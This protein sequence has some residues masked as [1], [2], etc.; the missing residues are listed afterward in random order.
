M[1]NK[2]TFENTN[3]FNIVLIKPNNISHLEYNSPNYINQILNNDCYE[4]IPCNS[5]NFMEYLKTL[6]QENNKNSI[7]HNKDGLE[8]ISQV[9]HEKKDYIYELLYLENKINEKNDIASLLNNNGTNICG[10]AILMKTYLPSLTNDNQLSETILIEDCS[11]SD[12]KTILDSRVHINIVSYDGEWSNTTTMY[13]IDSFAEEFFDDKY[14]KIEFPFLMHNINIW[15]EVGGKKTICDKL[16]DKPV[17]KCIFFTMITDKYF[18]NIYLEEV[19]KII[20][21]SNYLEYP[22]TIKSEWVP[23]KKDNIGREVIYNKYKILDYVYNLY[24]K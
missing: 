4:I 2:F 20:K 24:V 9:I 23:E 1:E 10:S 6:V 12:V 14:E 8:I 16:I 15:Y 17:C 19:Q 7:N 5:N 13:N 11:L 21:L 18:G 22:F 3:T